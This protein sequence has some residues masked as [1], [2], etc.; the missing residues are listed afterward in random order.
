MD[1]AVFADFPA[2]AMIAKGDSVEWRG[3]NAWFSALGGSFGGSYGSGN[4]SAGR[5][6]GA[7]GINRDMPSIDQGGLQ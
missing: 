3:D 4:A 2:A 7:S 6:L 1:V 5:T